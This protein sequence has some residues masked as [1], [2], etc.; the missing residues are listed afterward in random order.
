MSVLIDRVSLLVHATGDEPLAE[1]ERLASAEGLTLDVEGLAA[2]YARQKA[3]A[4]VYLIL[5]A[6]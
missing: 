6:K 5:P 2:H 4:V 3:R 1:V